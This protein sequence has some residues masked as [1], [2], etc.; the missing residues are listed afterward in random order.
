VQLIIKNEKIVSKRIKEQ[1]TA[2]LTY[3]KENNGK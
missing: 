3:K 2:F 1:L